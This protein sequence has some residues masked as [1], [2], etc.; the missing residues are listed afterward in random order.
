MT[1]EHDRFR[2]ENKMDNQIELNAVYTPE[3]VRTSSNNM[4]CVVT[5]ESLPADEQSEIEVI[6]AV[7][8]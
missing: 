3:V 6:L 5:Y 2:K 7:A 1:A 4:L 8:L